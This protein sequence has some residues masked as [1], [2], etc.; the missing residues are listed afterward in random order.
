MKF[1]RF[2]ITLAL[3]LALYRTETNALQCPISQHLIYSSCVPR[4]KL[5]CTHLT[6]NP[7][8]TKPC[9]EGCVCTDGYLYD[10]TTRRCVLPKQCPNIGKCAPDSSFKFCKPCGQGDVTCD[11]YG[12]GLIGC[13]A[14]CRAGCFCNDGLVRDVKSGRCI[15]PDNCPC[16]KGQRYVI[17]PKGSTDCKPGCQ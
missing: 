7:Y 15:P 1:S 4:D 3:A 13:S 14:Y 16:P 6:Y 10:E 5:T 8:D 2:G 11:T 12:L 17:C 9:T